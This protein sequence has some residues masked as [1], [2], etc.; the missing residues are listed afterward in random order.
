MLHRTMPL[1]ATVNVAS[2]AFSLWWKAAETMAASA[3]VIASRR[4]IIDSAMRDPMNAD[5]A[6]LGQMVS[7]KMDAFTRAALDA[8]ANG[9]ALYA[10]M[11][12]QMWDMGRPGPASSARMAKRS[13]RMAR[14]ALA[15]G[16]KAIGPVHSAVTANKKRLDRR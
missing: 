6:E 10:D 12:S 3:S 15:A 14:N 11:V 4:Q 1:S 2:S 9:W 5:A 7:E 8:S 16:H 13:R